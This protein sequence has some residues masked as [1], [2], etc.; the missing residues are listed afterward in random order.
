[1]TAPKPSARNKATTDEPLFTFEHDGQSYTFERPLS[2]VRS[3]RWVR[4]N[5][6]RDELDLMW[7]IV[8]TIAGDEALA[9]IDTMTEAEFDGLMKQLER[10]QGALR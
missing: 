10:E 7:T 8:E 1:M 2:A 5:R 4:A 9:A 3:P 6:R